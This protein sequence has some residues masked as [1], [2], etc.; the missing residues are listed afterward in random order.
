MLL[1]D[2][3]NGVT[4][5]KVA[6]FGFLVTKA[7]MFSNTFVD[8]LVRLSQIKNELYPSNLSINLLTFLFDTIYF[9]KLVKINIGI[10]SG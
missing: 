2:N 6:P 1:Q 7:S 9:S 3:K 10:M 4:F 5:I 8:D